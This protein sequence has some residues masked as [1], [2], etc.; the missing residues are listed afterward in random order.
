MQTHELKKE[1]DDR[2]KKLGSSKRSVLFK[3]FPGWL[4]E[5]IHRKHVKFVLSGCPQWA[6][7]FLDIGC[8]YG[9]ISKEVKKKYPIAKYQG[10]DLCTEFAHAYERDVGPCF[11]GPVQQFFPKQSFDVILIVTTL[12]YLDVSEE[13]ALL[14]RLWSSLNK[15]GRIICIEPASEIFALWRG[16]TGK[17]FAA[18]TGGIIGHST[19][20]ILAGKFSS[21]EGSRVEKTMSITLVPYMKITA[22]HHALIVTKV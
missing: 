3:R 9:R 13:K 22:L 4:N 2:H 14:K 12:M 7:S 17:P 18:P 21:L 19:K 6:S 1:W 5:S 10:V 15:S 8:G 16:M 11:Q 20:E